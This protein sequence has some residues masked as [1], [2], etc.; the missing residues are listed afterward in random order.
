M[1]TLRRRQQCHLLA[2]PHQTNNATS[3]A[4]QAS[5]RPQPRILGAPTSHPPP[6]PDETSTSSVNEASPPILSSPDDDG[7]QVVKVGN[8]PPSRSHGRPATPTSPP[9][10]GT[11]FD[12]LTDTKECP[13]SPPAVTSAQ[14]LRKAIRAEH[15]GIYALFQDQEGTIDAKI[16][17]V[18]A[19]AKKN[20][21]TVEKLAATQSTYKQAHRKYMKAL[22]DIS[23]DVVAH[24]ER[25]TDLASDVRLHESQLKG[26]HDSNDKITAALCSDLNDNRAKFPEF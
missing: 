25:L 17:A 8:R 6:A 9:T 2:P 11:R 12:V 14:A 10:F 15:P 13:V 7:F 3:F 21:A 4:R 18:L 5:P 22:G 19:I 20:A 26:Y 1:M 16:A 23:R 24:A